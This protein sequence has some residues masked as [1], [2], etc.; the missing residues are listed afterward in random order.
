MEF[1][2]LQERQDVV[3]EDTDNPQGHRVKADGIEIDGGL[4][5]IGDD[6][7]IIGPT[8]LGQVV[9]E[10]EIVGIFA[11]QQHA[12]GGADAATD[13]HVHL[14]Q[15]I[16]VQGRLIEEEIN[17]I[18]LDVSLIAHFSVEIHK[19]TE[20]LVLLQRLREEQRTHAGSLVDVEHQRHEGVFGI[21]RQ[22]THDVGLAV[23]SLAVEHH[24]TLIILVLAFQ[25]LDQDVENVVARVA[26]LNGMVFAEGVIE[27]V[28]DILLLDGGGE[29]HAQ[30]V[31]HLLV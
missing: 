21:H 5:H 27:Q 30:Q 12:V 31:T 14:I 20:V 19:T 15:L 23:D 29:G 2:L 10:V 3:I 4:I 26:H 28:D 11:L 1:V 6:D 9:G 22:V 18:P 16:A 13:R 8:H 24:M 7:A 17:L 25:V